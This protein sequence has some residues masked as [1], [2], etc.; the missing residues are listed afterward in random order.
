MTRT[1][2]RPGRRLCG[3]WCAKVSHA[4]LAVSL[5]VPQPESWRLLEDGLGYDCCALPTSAP[6]ALPRRPAAPVRRAMLRRLAQRAQQ[7]VGSMGAVSLSSL[8]WGLATLGQREGPL[9]DAVAAEA[10]ALGTQL[11]AQVW[12]RAESVLCICCARPAGWGGTMCRWRPAWTAHA[13]PRSTLLWQRLLLSCLLSSRLAPSPCLP[14]RACKQPALWGCCRALRHAHRVL[15][16]LL[17]PAGGGQHLLGLCRPEPRPPCAHG[18][19]SRD[20]VGDPLRPMCALLSVLCARAPLLLV[21]CVRHGE[22]Q[23]G[24]GQAGCTGQKERAEEEAG[25]ALAALTLC[26]ICCPSAN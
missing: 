12:E 16:S 13:R 23:A 20:R 9:L 1:T 19:P 10:T 22:G 5:A 7:E 6:P 17:P 8:I 21:L 15:V 4:A 2:A 25:A 14:A 3:T 24:R 18:A 11:D 26:L